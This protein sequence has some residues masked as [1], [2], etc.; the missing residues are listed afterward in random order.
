MRGNNMWQ[1]LFFWYVV[2]VLL[3]SL[4]IYLNI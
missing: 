2:A 1:Y 3:F 4:L